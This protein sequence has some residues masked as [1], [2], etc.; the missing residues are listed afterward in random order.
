MKVAK[1]TIAAMLN[2]DPA[3]RPRVLADCDFL[4]C[5]L[6][7]AKN[8]ISINLFVNLKC[9]YDSSGPEP[10]VYDESDRPTFRAPPGVEN[11]TL[12]DPKVAAANYNSAF[13]STF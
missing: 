13:E 4:D 2:K 9:S 6:S 1:R 10:Y 7:T 8:A 5:P 12:K 11:E 3:R